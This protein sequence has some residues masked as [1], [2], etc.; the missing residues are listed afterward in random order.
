MHMVGKEF[1]E[2]FMNKKRI[3]FLIIIP[4]FIFLFIVLFLFF[5][6]K[7]DSNDNFINNYINKSEYIGKN[8]HFRYVEYIGGITVDMDRKFDIS[9]R[10]LAFSGKRWYPFYRDKNTGEILRGLESYDYINAGSCFIGLDHIDIPKERQTIKG[11]QQFV[12]NWT[13]SILYKYKD[14]INREVGWYKVDDNGCYESDYST[15]YDNYIDVLA[16]YMWCKNRKYNKEERLLVNSINEIKN[17]GAQEESI[18]SG[19]TYM[20]ENEWILCILRNCFGFISD[21]FYDLLKNKN[22]FKEITIENIKIGDIGIFN[23]NTEIIRS[24]ICIG[25]DK[26]SNPVFS[27]CC[28]NKINKKYTELNKY[29][30]QIYNQ[31]NE[32]YNIVGFN[33][34]HIENLSS[35]EN[36][37]NKYYATNLPFVDRKKGTPRNKE[38]IIDDITRYNNQ[39]LYN[40][41]VL[42]DDLNKRLIDERERRIKEREFNAEL[43]REKYNIDLEKYKNDDISKVYFIYEIGTYDYLKFCGELEKKNYNMDIIKRRVTDE[44][45]INMLKDNQINRYDG[46]TQ[47]EIDAIYLDSLN[48]KAYNDFIQK[49]KQYIVGKT[50]EDIKKWMIN[51]FGNTGDYYFVI[52]YIKEHPECLD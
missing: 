19:Y 28:S 40:N 49:Y 3:I 8:Y 33:G 29:D 42:E 12:L 13:G 51:E 24:G 52:R 38:I 30:K 23:D 36:M 22:A 44:E 21:D 15:K 39:I 2:T 17:V 34:L 1:M 6:N 47:K 7:I 9:E 35:K 46:L 45:R 43:I 11:F 27:I 50:Y 16:E 25:F 41:N 14:R 5:I 32:F 37:F 26:N 18:E 4:S 48:Q 31:F 10:E 20:T